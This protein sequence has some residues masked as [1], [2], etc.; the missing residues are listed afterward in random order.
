MNKQAWLARSALLPGNAVAH[1]PGGVDVSAV[2]KMVKGTTEQ[3][4]QNRQWIFGSRGTMRIVESIL[5]LP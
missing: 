3:T 4:V 1:R 5:V 2:D